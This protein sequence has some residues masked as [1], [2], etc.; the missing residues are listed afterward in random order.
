M[1][2][3][4][5]ISRQRV[6]SLGGHVILLKALTGEQS[7]KAE[8]AYSKK[9]FEL[10]DQGVPSEKMV[11]KI[12]EKEV[13]NAG[14]S[15]QTI[16]EKQALLGKIIDNI[17]EFPELHNEEL[18]ENSDLLVS[19]IQ[20][21]NNLFSPEE[22]NALNEIIEIQRIQ[23]HYRQHTAEALAETEKNKH[24][25]LFTVYNP[26]ETPFWQ[27]IETINND[28]REE[29]LANILVEYYRFKRGLPSSF[30]VKQPGK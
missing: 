15:Y 12:I 24:I 5:A 9:L 22:I 29:L 27:T 6:V 7:Q 11:E 8:I 20:K 25:M 10:L 26:D 30:E 21:T 16:E 19:L 1:N 14:Y 28:T 23:E 3:Q 17:K 18:L 13:K 2:L 4:E